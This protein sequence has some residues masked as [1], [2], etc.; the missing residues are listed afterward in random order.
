MGLTSIRLLAR[1]VCVVVAL[2][3]CE[4]KPQQKKRAP[5]FDF[6]PSDVK[7]PVFRPMILKIDPLKKDQCIETTVVAITPRFETQ[8]ILGERGEVTHYSWAAEKAPEKRWDCGLRVEY[9]FGDSQVGYDTILSVKDDWQVGDTVKLCRTD[10]PGICPSGGMDE[11]AK[12]RATN[13]RTNTSWEEHNRIR[14]TC[15]PS[16]QGL[17]SAY[18]THGLLKL[19]RGLR[20][21]ETFEALDRY[22]ALRIRPSD[23]CF[24]GWCDDRAREI[25]AKDFAFLERT[26][27]WTFF[28]DGARADT[29]HTYTLSFKRDRLSKV[30]YRGPP[31]LGK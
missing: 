27:S 3:G 4:E 25:K 28:F 30:T 19:R 5:L 9:E 15:G 8:C 13:L 10:E 20:K 17:L 29:F 18:G 23:Y 1:L 16:D 21:K 6:S 31:P 7:P 26:D 2:V 12:Y 11:G 14:A 24:E 22:R